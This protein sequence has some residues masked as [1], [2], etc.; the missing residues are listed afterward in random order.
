MREKQVNIKL[1]SVN[2]QFHFLV[3]FVNT[4]GVVVAKYGFY[5]YIGNG[6]NLAM[7][8]DTWVNSGTLPPEMKG[9]VKLDN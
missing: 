4:L 1:A 9:L 5:N 8:C 3:E 2:F 7:A 6:E